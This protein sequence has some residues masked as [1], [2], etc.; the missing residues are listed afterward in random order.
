MRQADDPSEALEGWYE[1]SQGVFESDDGGVLLVKVPDE[2]E[3]WKPQDD[4]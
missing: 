1:R 3:P 2:A 4:D